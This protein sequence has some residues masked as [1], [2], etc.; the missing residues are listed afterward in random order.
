MSMYGALV[1]AKNFIIAQLEIHTRSGA[2]QK[3]A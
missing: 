1:A 2:I 3:T